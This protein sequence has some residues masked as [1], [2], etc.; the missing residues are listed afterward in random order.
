[1]GHIIST[2]SQTPFLP[3]STDFFIK[4]LQE[5][6]KFYTFEPQF[7]I[8]LVLWCNGSTADSGSVSLGSNPSKTTINT[9]ESP[10]KQDFTGL[11]FFGVPNGVPI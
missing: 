10:V 11:S 6:K 7:K 5:N 1:M 4:K 2:P 3:V 8:N 9:A